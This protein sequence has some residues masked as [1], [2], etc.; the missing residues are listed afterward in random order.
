MKEVVVE[1]NG[2][3]GKSQKGVQGA[4]FLVQVGILE[5]VAHRARSVST[6]RSRFDGS[7]GPLSRCGLLE[8]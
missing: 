1:S 3:N 6:V 8:E 5:T 7:R 2:V 4:I